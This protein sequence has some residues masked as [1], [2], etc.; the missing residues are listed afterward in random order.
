MNCGSVHGCEYV[1]GYVDFYAN[2]YRIQR[3]PMHDRKYHIENV[4]NG[5]CYE[6]RIELTVHQ[7]NII[8]EV[9][10]EIG[11]IL[12]LIDKTRK[13]MICAKFII[14]QIFMLIGLPFEFVK[15]SKSRKTL[16]FYNKYWVEILSLIFDR[17]VDIIKR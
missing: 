15:I 10:N 1:E 11:D 7:R 5:I 6:N 9:F 3:K 8:Y 4:L 16:A 17:I 2:I 12:P 14:R 13:R